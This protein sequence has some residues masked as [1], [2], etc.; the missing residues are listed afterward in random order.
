MYIFRSLLVH[1]PRCLTEMMKEQKE[2]LGEN[3]RNVELDFDTVG[4]MDYLQNRYHHNSHSKYTSDHE[5]S[6]SPF[7]FHK[8]ILIIIN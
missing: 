6:L 2:I 5:S 7:L 3:G 1:N 8:L 4:K